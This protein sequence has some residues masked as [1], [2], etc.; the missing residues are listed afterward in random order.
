MQGC[1]SALESLQI[2]TLAASHDHWLAQR[3]DWVAVLTKAGLAQQGTSE[4]I[5]ARPASLEVAR[6]VG[7]RNLLEGTVLAADGTW[8][9]VQTPLGVLKAPCRN[10]ISVGQ[11]VMLGVR[12]EEVFT[13]DGPE[14]RIRGQVRNLRTQGLRVRGELGVGAVGLD[15]LMPRYKQAQLELAEGRWLEVALEP[16]FLHLIPLA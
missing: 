13:L 12:P 3:A 4:E 2:P 8:A 15:F 6:L 11:R 10:G 5:F 1:W 16:R 9:Q 7:F 14:N